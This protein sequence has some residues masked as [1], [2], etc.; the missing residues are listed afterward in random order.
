MANLLDTI[1]QNQSAILG[2]Q[3]EQTD[4]TARTAALLRAKSGKAVSA[5]AVA[6]SNLAEQSANDVTAQQTEQLA[7]PAQ[8]QQA[9]LQQ[10]QVGQQQQQ[11]IQ[12]GEIAQARQLD[13]IQNRIKTDSLLS[14]L[15]RDKGKVDVDKDI[16]RLAQTATGLRLQN[17][18]Y[19]DNLQ[20]EGAKARLDNDLDFK[21]SLAKAVYG[22]QTKMLDDYFN[23]KD[24]MNFNQQQFDK[25]MTK[26]STQQAYDVFQSNVSAERGRAGWEALGSLGKAGASAAASGSGS[27]SGGSK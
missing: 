8:V 19:I 6:S 1:R 12:S 2:Q 20:R 17:Q 22:E 3:P 27:D 14:D 11:A 23:R 10:Q 16:A 18:Q 26:M 21:E 4:E 25:A 5:P 9:Q 13:T 24:W 15:E 7:I